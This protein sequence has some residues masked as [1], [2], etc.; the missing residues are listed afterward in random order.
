MTE[1]R[2]P[3]R[4]PRCGYVKFGACPGCF[5][6][7]AEQ[8]RQ[9]EIAQFRREQADEQRKRAG[10]LL[11]PEHELHDTCYR[12]ARPGELPWHRP[13]AGREGRTLTW[14]QAWRTLREKYVPGAP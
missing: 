14:D 2:Q 6:D 7:L 10:M 11:C 4:C 8:E 1:V 13:A 12:M 5:P 9:A 3:R